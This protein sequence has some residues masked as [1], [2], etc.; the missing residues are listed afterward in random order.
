[1]QL[2]QALDTFFLNRIGIRMLSGQHVEGR[3][4]DGGRVMMIDPERV[5]RRAADTAVRLCISL[6]GKAPEV[7]ITMAKTNVSSRFIYVESHLHHM[8]FELVKNSLRASVE[9]KPS[10][11]QS[12]ASVDALCRIDPVMDP[13]S[14]QL[15]FVIPEEID[16]GVSIYPRMSSSRSGEIPPVRI[17]ISPGVEDLTIKLSDEG[18]GICRSDWSKMWHY[19]YTTDPTAS[20]IKGFREQF[21]GGG[22]G[23]PIARLFA[24]YF[25]GELTIL[26]IERYGTDAF[27]QIHKLGKSY[28]V[29]PGH[30]NYA[31][32]PL[33]H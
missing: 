20:E 23:L 14:C 16:T 25:G 2:N 15:G 29:V 17:I 12:N 4:R 33:Q 11:D 27:I 6:Y 22:Y 26:P 30:S 13:T 5:A 3:E 10:A 32:A 21:S 24:R 7:Q 31:V 1:M 28:E 18:G 9:Y 19:T 8:I